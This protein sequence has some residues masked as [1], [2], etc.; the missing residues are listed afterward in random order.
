[1]QYTILGFQNDVS[2]PF[3][4]ARSILKYLVRNG[5][6]SIGEIALDCNL[7][8]PTIAKIME[9]LIT[10]GFVRD[11]GPRH[12]DGGRMPNMYDLQPGLGYF[13]GVEV[14]NALI[15]L[16][17]INF[18]GELVYSKENTAFDLDENV[19]EKQ[20]ADAIKAA[21]E[22]CPVKMKEIIACTI[23]VP[24]RINIHTQ[25]CLDYFRSADGNIVDILSK[26]LGV[27]V[28]IDNDSRVMCYGEYIHSK[29]SR[30]SEVLFIN[31]G[32]GLGMGMII[33][34]KLYYGGTGFS[35]EFGHVTMFDNEV[36]C[37]CGKKGCMETEA[38]GWAALRLLKAKHEAGARSVLSP[39]IENKERISAED[40][41]EAVI[42]GDMLMI[43]IVEEMGASL[44]RGI[45]AMV[46]IFNP[47]LV[48]I[49][50][51]MSE[52]GEHLLMSTV[53]SIRKYSISRVNR[54]TE[55][56]LG[57]TGRLSTILG[58]CYISRDRS[59]GII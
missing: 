14:N 49:G 47:Q 29:L 20:L 8:A 22:D 52:T 56:I 11:L 17:V 2:K 36:F 4:T 3:I 31:M 24:G 38:S 19:S 46:N 50:G 35:G 21:F 58:A 32:W 15:R 18:S 54:E 59:L 37:R 42:S 10:S 12:K 6:S 34:G 45:A 33:D 57:K 41:V 43:E 5:A 51:V 16:G 26:E 28:F 7:S 30:H 48:I 39:K 44:G 13:A 27:M 23:S 53:S 1:M 9:D 55:C 40:M 25:E